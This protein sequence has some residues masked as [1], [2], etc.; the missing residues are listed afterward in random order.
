MFTKEFYIQI[1][2]GGFVGQHVEIEVL[3]KKLIEFI[4]DV[5]VKAVII[6]WAPQKELYDAVYE[7]LKPKG[8]E[9]YLWYP[10]FSEIGEFVPMKKVVG[11]K[12]Q[13]IETFSFQEGENFEFYCPN[14][15]EN[16]K[17]AI[18]FFEEKFGKY[19]FDGVFLDKI[20]Y[21][22]FSN[23]L[24]GV[25]TCFCDKCKSDMEISGIELEGLNN[26]IERTFNETGFIKELGEKDSFKDENL[27]KFF[28]FKNRVIKES[29]SEI[30]SHFKNKGK[31]VGFDLFS[32]NISYYFGQDTDELFEIADFI[33]PMIYR[34]TN[35]PAGIPFEF[36]SLIRDSEGIV[37]REE[38]I[39]K[40]DLDE[41]LSIKDEDML[42]MINNLKTPEKTYIGFEV[43]RVEGIVQSN[44]K[45]LKE[46]LSIVEQSK[47]KGVVLSWNL[48]DMP[49]DNLEYI[50]K[51]DKN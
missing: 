30:V 8:I 16:I 20:R 45:Y 13:E 21:P 10:V 6:G 42:M 29:L 1:F 28:K 47:A 14:T 33:K 50:K 15:K 17:N 23:G 49:E 24:E 5:K 40:F 44:A 11:H 26:S 39:G 46:T 36:G 38:I 34:I 3:K 51:T 22:A 9:M 41:N 2:T 43:N 18:D 35:A 27:D 32:P 7:I 12:G 31:K 4:E 37:N 25:F 48:L 19:S